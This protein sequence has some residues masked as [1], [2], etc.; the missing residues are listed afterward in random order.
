MDEGE[1]SP[2]MRDATVAMRGLSIA[3]KNK[4]AA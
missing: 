2:W 1:F 4:L 3:T